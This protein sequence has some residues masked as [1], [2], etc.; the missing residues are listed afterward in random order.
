MFV[1]LSLTSV[2]GSLIS[3]GLSQNGLKTLKTSRDDDDAAHD[4]ELLFYL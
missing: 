2:S 4:V 1:R 3:F